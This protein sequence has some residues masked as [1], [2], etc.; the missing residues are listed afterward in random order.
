M[1]RL[2]PIIACLMLALV[3]FSGTMAHASEAAGPGEISVLAHFDGDGD[4]SPADEHGS[5]PHHHGVCHADH[6]GLA[7]DLGAAG[8]MTDVG[9]RLPAAAPLLLPSASLGAAL[10][11]PIA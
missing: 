5:V 11:P 3:L 1:R 8:V 2:L 9:T 10:R 4:Q 7:A 6:V